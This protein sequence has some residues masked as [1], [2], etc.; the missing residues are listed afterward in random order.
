MTQRYQ[1]VFR[2][3]DSTAPG[4]QVSVSSTSQAV[5]IESTALNRNWD[6][7]TGHSIRISSLTGSGDFYIAFG[8]STISVGTTNG[9]QMIGGTV[10]MWN[11]IKPSHGYIAFYSSTDVTAN[12]SIGY[13]Q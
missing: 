7:P 11:E 12:V 5:A 4:F 9:M 8:S 10:E 3:V 2:Q 6:G 1:G 13:G